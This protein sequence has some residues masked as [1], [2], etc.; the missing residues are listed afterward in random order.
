MSDISKMDFKELRS[1]VQILSDTVAKMKRM[2]EDII[3][4]LD[5]DNFSSQFIKEKDDMKTKIEV[6]AEGIKTMVSKTDLED[7]LSE[8]STIS[9]TATKIESAVTSVNNAT[10][11]KLKNY[12][13]KS[14]TAEEV[15]TRV[16]AEI[17]DLEDS[18][19]EA[20]Q[21]A[22][23]FESR[24]SNLED[25]KTSTFTQTA[26]GFTLDGEK[27]TFTGVIYLT[28]DNNKRKFSIFHDDSQGY[29]MILLHNTSASNLPIVIGDYD[30]NVYIGNYAD[31]HQVA[32]RNWV[33][34]NAGSGGSGGGG[35]AVFG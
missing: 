32:T 33:L 4:N 10:D 21:T 34:D 18:V 23:G 35:V 20:V 17:G 27:T 25:F 5:D 31:G 19:S 11:T 12:S 13:T 30:S 28:D 29:E 26:D 24:V 14:Q 1:E 6:T 7:S 2:Y 16:A 15:R 8:Y 3:Y 9:Q 22:Y